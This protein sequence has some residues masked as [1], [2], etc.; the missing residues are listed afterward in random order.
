MFVSECYVTWISCPVFTNEVV[1]KAHMTYFKTQ[2]L[3]I[4]GETDKN[5]DQHIM[6]TWPNETLFFHPC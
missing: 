3:H 5:H 1:K 2:S 6:M 4:P